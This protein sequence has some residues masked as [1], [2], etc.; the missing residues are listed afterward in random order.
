MTTLTFTP[1]TEDELRAAI[2]DE[3][4][5]VLSD[6]SVRDETTPDEIGGIDLAVAI[7]GLAK[8]TIYTLTSNRKIPFLK[9]GKRLYFSRQR[10]I[11]WLKEGEQKLESEITDQ[12]RKFKRSER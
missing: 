6:V 11:E 5:Q 2:R 8:P 9:R 3:L 4:K 12:A 7:T 10:L 1:L